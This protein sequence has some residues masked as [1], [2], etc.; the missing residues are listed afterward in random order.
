MQRYWLHKDDKPFAYLFVKLSCKD[1]RLLQS[2][3]DSFYFRRIWVDNSWLF[4]MKKSGFVFLDAA[5]STFQLLI[6]SEKKLK[7]ALGNVFWLKMCYFSVSWKNLTNCVFI[8]WCQNFLIILA[9]LFYISSLVI[10]RCARLLWGLQ[11]HIWAMSVVESNAPKILTVR[12][13]LHF[14][15]IA[16]EVKFRVWSVI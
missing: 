3:S 15:P 4:G 14:S 2:F 9:A 16:K 1:A 5:L 11:I 7:M 8:I 10:Q 6:F 13:L 12:I